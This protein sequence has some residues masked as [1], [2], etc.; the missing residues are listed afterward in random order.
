M[1]YNLL[2]LRKKYT[3]IT[4]KREYQ[5]K[6][7]EKKKLWFIFFYCIYDERNVYNMYNGLKLTG[8]NE[9]AI[10][11]LQMYLEAISYIYQHEWKKKKPFI[12]F[13]L[14]W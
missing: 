2:T 10:M 3:T 4:N 12:K 1:F 14:K 5:C 9:S 6:K 11:A 8:V 7:I 13:V